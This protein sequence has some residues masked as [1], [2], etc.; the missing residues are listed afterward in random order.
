MTT[1]RSGHCALDQQQLPR[2]VDAHDL[3]TLHRRADIA[4][5][6]WHALARKHTTRILRLTDRTRHIVRARVT[7]TGTIGREVV[8]FD[9]AREPLA[10]RGAG[11]VDELARLEQ[12]DRD[13]ATG[14]QIGQFGFRGAKFADQRTCFDASLGQVT[15]QRLVHPRCTALAIDHLHGAIAVGL[16]PL[17]LCNPVIGNIYYRDRQRCAVIGKNT[18]HAD[19]TADESECHILFPLRGADYDRSAMLSGT[20]RLLPTGALKQSGHKPSCLLLVTSMPHPPRP[21]N[22]ASSARQPFCQSGQ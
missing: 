17:H 13:S 11:N 8:T 9:N 21:A 4:Q 6:A 12:L 3:Q 22:R 19:L 18:G 16:R 7:V 10:D 20:S 2:N 1:G 14:G 15:G 5:M